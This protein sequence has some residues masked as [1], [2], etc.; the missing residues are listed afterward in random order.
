MVRKDAKIR[1]IKI[2]LGKRIK[3]IEL[4]NL[5]PLDQKIRSTR[6]FFEVS[7]FSLIFLHLPDDMKESLEWRQ[8]KFHQT[9]SK[10]KV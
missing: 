10:A 9:Q 8:S 1:H 5:F 7:F 4:L 2:S 6:S 3:C